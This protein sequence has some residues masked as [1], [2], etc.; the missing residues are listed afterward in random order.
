[1]SFR[2]KLH[3]YKNPRSLIR[4]VLIK[5]AYRE[6]VDSTGKPLGLKPIIG[7]ATQFWVEQG[8]T[9]P[10]MWSPERCH[11]YWSSRSNSSDSNRPVSYALKD[12]SIMDFVCKLW[13]PEVDF[14]KSILELGCN[15]GVNLQSLHTRGYTLLSGVEINPAAID[16]LRETFPELGAQAKI[17]LGPLEEVLPQLPDDSVDVAFTMAVSMHIHPR[18]H[19]LFAEM[20]RV[21]RKHICTIELETA[22]NSYLFPRNYERVFRKLG[23]IQVRS[24]SLDRYTTPPVPEDYYGIKV[25]LFE[26]K[27]AH[28][29]LVASRP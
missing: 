3:K 2:T 17:F 7:R 19:F 29:P 23:A 16:Q 11:R 28:V 20:A 24:A 21:A 25:R 26:L 15:C 22:A 5:L 12:T 4:A 1:M 13:S 27:T 10:H 6:R 9:A 8:W 14:G 18:S